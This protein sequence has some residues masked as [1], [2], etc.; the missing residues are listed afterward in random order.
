VRREE[1]SLG[2]PTKREARESKQRFYTHVLEG[3][4]GSAGLSRQMST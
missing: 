1:R 2:I 3:I 4:M